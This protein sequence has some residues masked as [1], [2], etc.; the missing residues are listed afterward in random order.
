[1]E[2]EKD[3]TEVEGSINFLFDEQVI[4]AER[5]FSLEGIYGELDIE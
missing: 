5:L 3:V 4:Q 1:M 2:I